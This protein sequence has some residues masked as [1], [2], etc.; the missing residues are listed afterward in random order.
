MKNY[1]KQL[2][3]LL[4]F[5]LVNTLLIAQIQGPAPD[6]KRQDWGIVNWDGTPRSQDNS[7][8]EWWNAHTKI[9]ESDGNGGKTHIGYVAVG[10]SSW[11]DAIVTLQSQNNCFFYPPTGT[12]IPGADCI[13]FENPTNISETKG[14]FWQ[15]M[16]RYDLDGKMVWCKRYNQNQF[17]KVIQD[18]DFNIVAIGPTSSVKRLDGTAIPYNPSVSNTAGTIVNCTGGTNYSSKLN[19]VK[20]DLQGDYI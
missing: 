10:Y 8:D 4:T 19:V 17:F 14:I 13:D 3:L 18:E 9:Y 16:A 2:S 11:N 20:V 5:I 1:F 15:I 6:W 7:G 12:P